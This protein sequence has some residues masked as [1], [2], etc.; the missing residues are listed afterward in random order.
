MFVLNA[1]TTKTRYL[2]LEYGKCG[3]VLT[4][5]LKYK[6]YLYIEYAHWNGIKTSRPA[7]ITK[8]INHFTKYDTRIWKTISYRKYYILSFECYSFMCWNSDIMQFFSTK[9]FRLFTGF[10]KVLCPFIRYFTSNVFLFC[11]DVF[12]SKSLRALLNG[13]LLYVLYKLF[14]TKR[15]SA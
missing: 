8:V 5:P 9:F 11:S 1:T 14:I 13:I 15:R 2:G 10:E 4:K 7:V 12:R 6:E 3:K